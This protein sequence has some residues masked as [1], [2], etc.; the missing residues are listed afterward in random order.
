MNQIVKRPRRRCGAGTILP[1]RQIVR[2][3]ESNKM[4]PCGFPRRRC[5]NTTHAVPCTLDK[6]FQDCH[7]HQ[8]H[9]LCDDLIASRLGPNLVIHN[10]TPQEYSCLRPCSWIAC[11]KIMTPKMPPAAMAPC[12]PRIEIRE[13]VMPAGGSH[14]NHDHP[15]Q[16]RGDAESGNT[17]YRA[18]AIF[19]GHIQ[20]RRYISRRCHMGFFGER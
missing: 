10:V 3:T 11:C 2:A 4:L 12:P 18:C 8:P 15:D 19:Y 20:S 13:A 6:V 14:G 9:G 5:S 1:E 16:A 7:A 17:V